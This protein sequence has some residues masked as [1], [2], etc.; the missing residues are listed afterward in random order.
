VSILHVLVADPLLMFVTFTL[1]Y[2]SA[3][4]FVELTIPW[5]AVSF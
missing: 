3:D 5:H 4:A 1:P 2:G